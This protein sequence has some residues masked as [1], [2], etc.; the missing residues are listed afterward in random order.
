MTILWKLGGNCAFPLNF[1]PSKLE[2]I[3][4]FYAVCYFNRT[5]EIVLSKSQPVSD[6]L[7]P[8]QPT[9]AGRIFTKSDVLR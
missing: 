2:D 7:L 9:L 5:H 4:A 3:T 6:K 1:Y 8:K